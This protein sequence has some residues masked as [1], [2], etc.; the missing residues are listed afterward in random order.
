MLLFCCSILSLARV[1]EALEHTGGTDPA[2]A[3][4]YLLTA[5]RNADDCKDF[6]VDDRL[7]DI[8][9]M[10]RDMEMPLL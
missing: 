10:K 7:M 4:R 8:E 2:K 5:K 9:E 3:I 1:Q 6:D